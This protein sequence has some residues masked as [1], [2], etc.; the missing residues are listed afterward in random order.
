[1]PLAEVTLDWQVIEGHLSNQEK[2]GLKI[3]LVAV[4]NEVVNQYKE[5]SKLSGLELL[6]LE[7]EVF[8]LLRS[9]G[10][11]KETILLMDIGAQSTTCSIVE[12]KVL[13]M[14]YSFDMSGN[15]LTE[16]I[17]KGMGVDYKTAESLKE[18]YGILSDAS[19][20]SPA[21]EVKQIL[22]PLIDV[23]IKEAERILRNFNQIIPQKIII[24]GAS[25]SLPGLKEHFQDYFK[26]EVISV[27]PF[28]K[29][30]KSVV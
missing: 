26:K 23:I 7:A 6:A 1:M 15:E 3:L 11:Q 12:K 9:L 27:N 19:Q 5:I 29:D 30:R 2:A 4:P 22:I 18:R 17:S 13:K 20:E 10:E 24:A 21:V 28:S 14:S 25:A 8:G 16:V